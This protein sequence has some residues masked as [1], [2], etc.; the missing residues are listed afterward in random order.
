M[1]AWLG[2]AAFAFRSSLRTSFGL[3]FGNSGDG[4][5]IAYLHEHLFAALQGR[6][7]LLSPAFYF[8]QENALGYTDAFLLDAL[9]FAALRGLGFDPF[10]ASQILA[11]AL[12]L[13]CFMA[14][15]VIGRRYLRLGPALAICAAM[16][17]TFPNNLMFKTAE[18]HPNFFALYYVPCLV[19]L[20]L[21]AIEDFPRPTKWSLLR[22]GGFGLGYGLL[23]ATSFYVAWLFA[24]TL[25][26]GLGTIAVLRGREAI[27]LL[28]RHPGSCAALIGAAIAG[29]AIGA[30]PVLA[31]YLPALH[32]QAGRSF[33][34]YVSFAPF[35]KDLINLGVHN[36]AWGWLVDR[37]IGDAQHERALAVTPLMTAAL[38]ILLLRLRRTAPA[39]PMPWQLVFASV[40][41]AVWGLSWLVTLR[42]GTFSAFW[43][44]YHLVPGAVAIRAGDRIQLLVNLWVVAGLV[45][46]LQYWLDCAP[47]A[48][49]T[50]RKLIAG[51][52][53]ALCLI[54]QINLQP[55]GLER[56]EELARLAA[57]PAAPPQCRAFVV[58]AGTAFDGKQLDAMWIS[59]KLGLP[60]LNGDSGWAPPGWRLNDPTIDYDEAVRLWIAATGLDVPLCRYDRGARQWSPDPQPADELSAKRR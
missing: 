26:F 38:V 47:R 35:P 4:R 34:D 60:T 17:V 44:P 42:V 13:C 18:A 54:E 40:C 22:A 49:G 8:P 27:A 51:V 52:V 24:L 28:R 3:V 2:A 48:A 14:T 21:W 30:I 12:S 39:R 1:A 41:V 57:V 7:E 23:F 36:M 9:P 37:L 19:L 55:A 59:A 20:A 33:R 11:I 31:I 16:L 32:Q 50:R 29:F 43:L 15:L 10:L 45:V 25:L 58:D 46:L 6:A 56:R 5:L 53:A